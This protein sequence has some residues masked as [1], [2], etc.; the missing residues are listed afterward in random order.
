MFML[1][2]ILPD[3]AEKPHGKHYDHLDTA[4]LRMVNICRCVLMNR[5]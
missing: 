3:I 1:C 2:S 4:W 5:K